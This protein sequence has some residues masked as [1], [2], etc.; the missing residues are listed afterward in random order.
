MHLKRNSAGALS[1]SVKLVAIFVPGG[2]NTEKN[3]GGKKMRR[4][5]KFRGGQTLFPRVPRSR[6]AW[7]VLQSTGNAETATNEVA[8]LS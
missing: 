3:E 7:E 1:N 6:V 2:I 5:R 4:W 8:W